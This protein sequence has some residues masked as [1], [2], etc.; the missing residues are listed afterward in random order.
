M[1]PT[2]VGEAIALQELLRTR[3]SLTDDF[4]KL[5]RVA[6]LD[7]GFIDAGTTARAA[8]VVLSFPD[9]ELIDYARAYAVVDFPYVPGLL[10]FRELP[11]I[12]KAL[13][14]LQQSPDLL[15]CDGHG[16]AHPRRLVT[17]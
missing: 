16:I 10:A 17:L 1:R 15:I 11:S 2:S 5:E 3:L 14:Q 12:L 6:G 4:G 9:L 7:V 13:E 8:V